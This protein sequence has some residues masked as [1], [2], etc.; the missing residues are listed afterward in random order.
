[1]LSQHRLADQEIHNQ[2]FCVGRSP[3]A[4]LDDVLKDEYFRKLAA[5]VEAK[6]GIRLPPSK[7][8]MVEGRLRP[9]ARAL[10]LP[11]LDAYGRHL[12]KEGGLEA[13]F[14]QIIDCVTTNKTDFFR[15]PEHFEILVN[16]LVPDLL[17]QRRD[18]GRRSIKLW[19]AAASS[20]AEAYTLAMV[21]TELQATLPCEFSILGTDISTEIL[22]EARRAVYPIAMLES[23]PKKCQKLYTMQAKDQARREFRIPPELRRLVRLQRLNLI[24]KHYDVERDIDVIF[25][26]NVLIYLDRDVQRAVVERLLLHLRQNGYLILGHAEAM[27]GNDQPLLRQIAPT[28]FQLRETGV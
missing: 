20:G 23:I 16:R 22:Q 8:A 3:V 13:E 26:R 17:S 1:M 10:G 19:S 11:S 2:S 7:K 5:Q 4:L 21:M 9:R 25:C 14:D 27:A 12:F 6:I 28:V 15:E 18:R 24:G